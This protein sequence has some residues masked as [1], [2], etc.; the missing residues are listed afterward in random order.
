MSWGIFFRIVAIDE[1]R[2]V[3][4][5]AEERFQFVMRSARQ[6]G[7]AGNLVAVQ[8]QHGQHGADPEALRH[9][10]QLGV[11]LVL[12]ARCHRPL[13]CLLHFGVQRAR[14]NRC[15]RHGTPVVDPRFAATMGGMGSLLI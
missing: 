4:V 2:R 5:A 13:M 12:R 15:A 7:G 10:T 6:Y 3:T 9:V 11:L 1:R 14:V 8:M